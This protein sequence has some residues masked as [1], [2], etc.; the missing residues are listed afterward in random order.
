LRHADCRSRRAS[1]PLAQRPSSITISLRYRFSAPEKEYHAPAGLRA[2][3]PGPRVHQLTSP[4][5]TP[6][7]LRFASKPPSQPTHWLL[8]NNVLSNDLISEARPRGQGEKE[9]RLVRGG[10]PSSTGSRGSLDRG[11]ALQAAGYEGRRRVAC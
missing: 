5:R 10:Y 2:S 9:N 11:P 3:C 8:D 4:G 7:D 1:Q 6:A